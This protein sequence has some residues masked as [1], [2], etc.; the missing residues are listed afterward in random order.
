MAKPHLLQEAS[1]P[2]TDPER[3]RLLADH[4]DDAV[5]R[6]AWRNPSLPEEAWREALIAGWPEPWANP[7][8]PIYL[9][10]WTPREDDAR[11]LDQAAWF[12]MS[13]LWR[14]RH[15]CSSQAKALLSARVQEAWATSKEADDMIWFLGKWAKAKGNG[16]AEHRETVRLLVLCVRTAHN[17]TA[18]DRQA[19]D[20]LE[21]WT[22]G[23]PDRRKKAE[24]LAESQAVKY[25][26]VFAVGVVEHFSSTP[27]NAIQEVLAIFGGKE[28]ASARA[29]HLRLMAD[30]IRREM[31]LP[32]VVE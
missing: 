4:E 23:G 14:N 10:T 1:D 21:S 12:A 11:T 6:F 17:L 2:A 22:A 29:E 32:P 16:S 18:K 30:L 27:W 7:M 20:F 9:L 25:T 24:A 31:P 15:G 13:E 8:A 26:V 28:G 19:L 5:Q 3:L